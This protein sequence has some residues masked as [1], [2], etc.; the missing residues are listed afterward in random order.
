MYGVIGNL[1]S[2]A[3]EKNDDKVVVVVA[4]AVMVQQ[5][6]SV[7][8]IYSILYVH[9]YYFFIPTFLQSC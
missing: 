9:V 3:Q 1:Q 2:P 6:G 4:V 7:F 8:L 5:I